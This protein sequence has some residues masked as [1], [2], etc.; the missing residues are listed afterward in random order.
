MSRA[1]IKEDN[2]AVLTEAV[3]PNHTISSHPNLVTQTGLKALEC[4]LQLAR[5][6][7]AEAKKAEGANQRKQRTSL[8]LRDIK[9]YSE[10][11]LTAKL[12]TPEAN[13]RKIGFGHLVSLRYD[14][15]RSLTYRLVGEDESDP[16]EG[17]I[18]F[19][20]PVAQ[21]LMGKSV[22]DYVTVGEHEIEILDIF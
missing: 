4:Q 13:P 5:D 6:A 18:S 10:R 12:V 19:V 3:L 9:Y 7:L 22:G 1:F 17:R 2:A 21:N 16:S 11:L 14:D 15:G 20:S 8:S